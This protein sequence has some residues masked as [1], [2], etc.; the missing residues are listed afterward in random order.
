MV[1]GFCLGK[2]IE[3]EGIFLDTNFHELHELIFFIDGFGMGCFFWTLI[4]M[5]YT[6]FFFISV[7]IIR[8]L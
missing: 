5:D 6:N 7:G 4:F 3:K 8:I 2:D 1:D